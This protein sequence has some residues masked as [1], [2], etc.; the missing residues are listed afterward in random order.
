[1]IKHRGFSLIELLVGLVILGILF[2]FSLPLGLAIIQKN[3]L[4][5]VKNE[6]SSAIHYAKTASVLRGV[7]LVLAPLP[8]TNNWSAGMLL[9]I[10]NET[11]QFKDKS[12]LI[13]EWHWKHPGIQ[14]SW[15]GLYTQN[16]LL[17]TPSLQT[18]ALSGH[19]NIAN[20]EGKT[21]KLILNRLGR[22]RSV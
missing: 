12:E 4:E 11:H 14:I 10:D 19:F 7:P 8:Q 3:Q 18:R 20:K 6:I 5:V 21:I 13:H 15:Q 9:F 2:L 16:Y 22:I 1:M 17:F